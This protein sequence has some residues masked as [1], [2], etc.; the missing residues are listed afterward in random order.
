MRVAALESEVVLGAGNEERLANVDFVKSLEIEI[1]TI[2]EIIGSRRRDEI[3]EDI[4][5]VQ[6][7]VGNQDELGDAAS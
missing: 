4:D 2:Q 1:A 5:I 7:P 3:V 6:F